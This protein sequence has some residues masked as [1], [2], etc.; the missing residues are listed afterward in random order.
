MSREIR[1][2]HAKQNNL[3]DVSLSIPKHKITVFTGVSGSGKSSLVIDTLGAESQRFLNETYSSYIQNLLPHYA[4]PSVEAIEG[5]PVSIIIN[6][7]K[8][9]GNARSTVGTVTDIYALLRLLYSRVGQPFVGYSMVFSFNNRQGMCERCEGLGIVRDVDVEKL[10]DVSKSLNEGA[11][12]FPTFQPG[13]WRLSRYTESG[14]FDNDLPI[15]KYSD[16]EKA[17]LLFGEEQYPHSPSVK[18]HKSAK[19]IGIVP[20]IEDVFLRKDGHQYKEE[21]EGIVSSE[22]CPICHG[23]RLNSKSLSC[24]IQGKS[25]SDCVTMSLKELYSFLSKINDDMAIDL[26]ERILLQL[27]TLIRLGLGYLSLQRMTNTLSGGESQRVKMSKYLNGSLSDVLYIFDEPSIGLHPH[28]LKGVNA[29]LKGLVDKGNTVIAVEHDPDII[30][31]ADHIIDMG[32]EA[33]RSGGEICFEGSYKALLNSQTKTGMAL[34]ACK[35]LKPKQ[36][37]F[38]DFYELQNVSMFN[39]KNVSVKIPK[40]GLT[41]VT[42]VAGS[43]KSTLISRLFVQKYSQSVLLDQ[44]KIYA[45]ERSNIVTFL[46]IFDDIRDAFA[47]ATGQPLSLFSFNGKGRCPVCKGRGY[48]KTDFAFLGDVELVCDAC[49]GTRYSK[50]ALKHK[51]NGYDMSD[52]LKMSVIGALEIFNCTKIQQVLEM[53]KQVNLGYIV[54]GQ[55]LDSFSGG[56]LQRLKLAKTL[57]SSDRDILVLDEPS[58]GLHEFDVEKLLSLF[59]FIVSQGKTLIVMEHNLSVICHADWVIDLG[60]GGG[61]DGGEVLYIGYL[62][63][64]LSC[65]RSYSKQ[66][67][68]A[69]VS[70][71][72]RHKSE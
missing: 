38:K 33:G 20:R 61:S 51:Y 70:L 69:Y 16:R 25:I 48:I 49:H 32:P 50:T 68:E 10:I 55:S 34:R 1:I 11:I 5:L 59:D 66:S 62:A 7:K 22:V 52:V 18:W 54:L 56:E 42:G 8:L 40:Q 63:G 41:V 3:K 45:S 24:K 67:L 23:Y 60:P 37:E 36:F 57:L 2:T 15:E 71:S 44:S 72:N 64:L 14:F 29:L 28:D 19:Y 53:V 47:K 58:T 35:K 13:G 27:N 46:D 43:G 21:L 4:R 39:I 31:I 9:G 65:E 12:R 30:K 6:Q 26:I 17:L